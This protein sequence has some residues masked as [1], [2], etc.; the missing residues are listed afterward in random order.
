[1]ALPDF[2]RDLS[3]GKFQSQALEPLGNSNTFNL[4]IGKEVAFSTHFDL[5]IYTL[6]KL[7]FYTLFLTSPVEETAVLLPVG[8]YFNSY[9]NKELTA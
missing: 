6:P 9:M 1:M 5:G 7:H 3:I 2:F 4:S 8:C